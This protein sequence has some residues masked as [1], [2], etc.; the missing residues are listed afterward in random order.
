M[1]DEESTPVA[2]PCLNPENMGL[3]EAVNRLR[4]VGETFTRKLGDI[5]RTIRLSVNKYGPEVKQSLAGVAKEHA[6]IELAIAQE[7][8]EVA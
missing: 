8:L 2:R 3:A 7:I 5:E 4:Y 6:T 1:S